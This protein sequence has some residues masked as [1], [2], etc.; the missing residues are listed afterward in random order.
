MRNIVTLCLLSVAVSVTACGT[1]LEGSDDPPA[2]ANQ[3]GGRAPLSTFVPP[4]PAG[5]AGAQ[6]YDVCLA[7]TAATPLAVRVTRPA[8]LRPNA[9]AVV[10]FQR[11]EGVRGALDFDHAN[12]RVGDARELRLYFQLSPGAYR[13]SVGVDADGD[14]NAEGPAD[15]LGWSAASPD[16]PVLDQESA[17]LVDVGTTPIATSFMLAPRR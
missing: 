14:G 10:R 15:D 2:S 17:A 4:T 12:F 9:V 5:C 11:V 16:V 8:V 3:G 1:S 7:I 13:I 6:A